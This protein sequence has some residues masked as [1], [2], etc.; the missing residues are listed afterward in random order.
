MNAILV[1]SSSPQG[2]GLLIDL[3]KDSSLVSQIDQAQSGSS[4]RR[5][6]IEKEYALVLINAPLSDEFGHELAVH[7][8]RESASGVVLIVK[9]E[10][11]DEVYGHVEND[12]VLVV[13][14]PVGKALFYQALK[15]AA[16]SHRRVLG[17]RGA[18]EK[19]QNKI[20]EMRMVDRAKRALIHYLDMTE[21]QAHRY[22]E[23]QAM[24][25]R[26]TRQDVARNILQAYEQ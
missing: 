11:A 17:L 21:P 20:E 1:V 24:D 8:S 26:V 19:L 9:S 25:L 4:A 2:A 10:L 22:I 7:V 18:N 12:G 16:A 5:R 13:S 3:I 15:L 23:K 6:L 14:K